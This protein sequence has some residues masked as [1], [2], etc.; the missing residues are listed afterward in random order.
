METLE[1]VYDLYPIYDKALGLRRSF[2]LSPR[3]PD[4]DFGFSGFRSVSRPSS[5]RFASDSTFQHGH[6]DAMSVRK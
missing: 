2:D 5:F 1:N 4:L 3:T 6:G